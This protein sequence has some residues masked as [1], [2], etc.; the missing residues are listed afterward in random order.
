MRLYRKG[1][2]K[3]PKDWSDRVAGPE[4]RQF[5]MGWIRD[6]VQQLAGLIL[7]TLA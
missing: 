5:Q 2:M 3:R 7:S 4:Q 1:M 6:S